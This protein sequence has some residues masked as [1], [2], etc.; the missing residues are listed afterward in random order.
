MDMSD[1][2]RIIRASDFLIATP[3]GE[4]DVEKSK[5]LLTKIAAAS[6]KT[7][8]RRVLLDM[9]EAKSKLSATDIWYLA[10]ELVRLRPDYPDK[11]AV[12]CRLEAAGRGAFF[13]LCAQ[14]RGLPVR[15]FT[16]FESAV[17]WLSG[18]GSEQIAPLT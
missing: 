2:V 18:D 9:R 10:G 6:S 16:S 14:N 8:T 7:A 17:K 13:S 5:Q 3:T 4:V 1:D 15:E 11:I 12:I